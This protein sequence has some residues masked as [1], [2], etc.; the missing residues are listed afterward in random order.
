MTQE[1]RWLAVYVALSRPESFDQ[2]MSVH[3]PAQFRS[4]LEGGPPAGILSKFEEFFEDKE[5]LTTDMAVR[6]LRKLGWG[7]A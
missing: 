5:A 3:L 6:M 1:L 4:I 7:T 2:L